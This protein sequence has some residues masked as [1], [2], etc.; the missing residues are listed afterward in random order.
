VQLFLFFLFSFF[1]REQVESSSS[2]S[3]SSSSGR[4]VKSG[5]KGEHQ[6][7]ENFRFIFPKIN[8]PFWESYL[9]PFMGGG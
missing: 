8:K 7:G 4:V 5:K 6:N 2:S 3:S 9:L 1:H